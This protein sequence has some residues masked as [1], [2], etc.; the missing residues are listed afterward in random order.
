MKRKKIGGSSY[1]FIKNETA[2]LER[3]E[4][5]D[6]ETGE[7]IMDAYEPSGGSMNHIRIILTIGAILVGLGIISF[8]ASN[9]QEIGNEAKLSI[10][11]SGFLG[12]ALA[13]R[14]LEKEYPKT[15]RSLLYISVL[16]FGAGIFL[17]EQMY[18]ISMHFSKSFLL[19][20]LGSL[21]MA[22]VLKD[23]LLFFFGHGLLLIHS[24]GNFDYSGT[25]WDFLLV[26]I[27]LYAVNRLVFEKSSYF[28][29]FQNILAALWALDLI[30]EMNGGD[31][32]AAAVI[33]G[34]GI[35]MKYV[36]SSREQIL[37]LEGNLFL[38]FSGLAL[39]FKNVWK[40]IPL[41]YPG[42]AAI[43]FGIALMAY[44][45]FDTRKGNISSLF[46]V[47]LII[48]RYYVDNFYDFMPKSMFFI[49][50][51]LILIAFGYWFERMRKKEGVKDEEHF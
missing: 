11:V 30:H 31:F 40:D 10:L 48:F 24:L 26:L 1:R 9:W 50:G 22:Y 42:Q 20:S 25:A 19:W 28:M 38:G 33:F 41:D 7:R 12:F 4:V 37:L 23:R 14:A 51:G 47:C 3:M 32:L 36:L 27:L 45:L 43:I 2:Y 15:G 46:F 49:I 21:P 29:F 5:I 34:A 44:F 39:T 18:N 8:I 35:L 6:R 16:I 13:G 17:V